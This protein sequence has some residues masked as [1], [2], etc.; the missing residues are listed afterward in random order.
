[1]IRTVIADDD[2]LVRSYLG[3]LGAWERAGYQLV[4]DCRDG[5]EALHTVE[6][7]QPDVLITDISMPVMNG[8]ELIRQ[9]RKK[10]RALYIIVLS[11]HDDFEYVKEAIQLGADEYV[12]KNS[13]NEKTLFE[14]LDQTKHQMASRQKENQESNEAQ[15]L[16]EMGRHT[17]K[18]HF[19]NGLLADSF[20]PE[21][22]EKRRVEAGVQAKYVNS[23]V[24]TL[25]IPKWNALK[26]QCSPL[27]L[28]QYGQQ[29][30]QKLIQ[31]LKGQK[32][33]TSDTECVY[34]GEGVFCCFLDLSDLRR[35]S[36]MKQRLTNVATA[37]FHCCKEEA[38]AF[39][40]GVSSICFGKEGIRRAYQ[41]AREML[42]RS[43]Y[44]KSEILYY[45]EGAEI[46]KLLPKEA[47]QLLKEAQQL[48]EGRQYEALQSGFQKVMEECKKQYTDSRLVL[49]WLKALDQKLKI[50]R[51][52]EEYA[53]F[54]KIEQLTDVCE[55]YG[56]KL[57]MEKKIPQNAGPAVRK[58]IEFLRAH[59]KEPIG[60]TEAAE[61]ARLNP[62]YLSYL[63]KQEL[64]YGFSGY[65]LELRME[66][67]KALLRSTNYKIK[68]VIVQSGFNDYHYFSKV[69]KRMNGISPADYRKENSK[70]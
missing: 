57:F 2:F 13:L 5:E 9:I 10:N 52:P 48:V 70:F 62:A 42:K 23:A 60:L 21:E 61:A 43:F 29:F 19:F 44:D 55:E 3:Q 20:S 15:H 54:I 37:C 69:F 26:T 4:G 16:M 25:C 18:C 47:E 7:L 39:E 30:L 22:Q 63:F 45:E 8:I 40:I 56:Q 64:G 41:Q 49:H 32:E 67:A 31:N 51:P 14:I 38:Y 66:C 28:E 46:G 65:L 58:V 24:I 11:C 36:M 68:E 12:L 59:Y 1:M 50:E 53:D 34:L 35:S 27:E 6:T 33:N 17:L